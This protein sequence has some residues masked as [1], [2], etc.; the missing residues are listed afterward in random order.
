[1][2]N[3]IIKCFGYECELNSYGTYS[4][5]DLVNGIYIDVYVPPNKTIRDYNIKFLCSRGEFIGTGHTIKL[6][7]LILMSNI[8]DESYKLQR[9]YNELI[10]KVSK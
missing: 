7:E 6:A 4:Y 8:L 5:K 1:M 9:I 3:K 10:S 2:S